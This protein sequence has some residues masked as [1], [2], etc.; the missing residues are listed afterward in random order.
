[1]KK[2]IF[3]KRTKKNNDLEPFEQLDRSLKI[4]K[5]FVRTIEL[6]KNVSYWKFSISVDC[7]NTSSISL[8]LTPLLPL[9]SYF[10]A[11][12]SQG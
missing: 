11:S 7:N 1:M 9:V 2:V 4:S 5:S 6:E 10:I 3:E 12:F 8:Q